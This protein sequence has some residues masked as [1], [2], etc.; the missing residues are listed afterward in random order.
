MRWL[1][2]KIWGLAM[3]R[4]LFLW[5]CVL[6]TLVHADP[7][8]YTARTQSVEPGGRCFVW[9]PKG[10]NLTPPVLPDGWS[11]KR[12]AKGTEDWHNQ[13]AWELRTSSTTAPGTYDVGGVEVVVVKPTKKSPLKRIAVTDTIVDAQKWADLGYDLELDPGIHRWD[14]SLS[15]PDGIKISSA[16]A[17]IIRQPNGETF[18]RMF[19][20]QGGFSLDGLLLTHSE[21]IPTEA[22]TYVHQYPIKSGNVTIR[23]CT[24]RGG[25]LAHQQGPGWLVDGCNF[26]HAGTGH[27]AD[28]SVWLNCRFEGR[29]RQGH[30]PFFNTGVPALVCSSDWIN[31]NRAI[32]LQGA[33]HGHMSIDCTA[34]NIG[35]GG[36]LSGSEVVLLETGSSV[37]MTHGPHDNTF[38]D[39][40]IRNCCGPGVSLYGSGHHDNVFWNVNSDVENTS[41]MVC[42]FDNGQMDNNEFHNFQCTGGLDI[43]GNVGHV[44]FSNCQM[45]QRVQRR[46]N[47]GP[48]AS[49]MQHFNTH[50][51]IHA[52]EEARTSG[53]FTW[54]GCGMVRT[55]RTYELIESIN[56]TIAP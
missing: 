18:E 49:M 48:F 54:L 3:T 4:F 24:I 55:N 53:L 35:P 20:P 25:S 19:C 36:V 27:V 41:L 2:N 9:F 6:T 1:P 14:H 50:Y 17:W 23:N 42:E 26:D 15:L 40:E 7:P 13:W 37:P 5:L 29:T 46:G 43:R 47:Q 44:T 56:Y 12:P 39:I 21:Q 30:H 51:P 32:V 34:S 8:V 22:I 38:V 45:V 31:T 28:C 11:F 16:G 10:G 33:V 52:D